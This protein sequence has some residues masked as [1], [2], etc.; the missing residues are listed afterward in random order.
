MFE[1]NAW[2]F[3]AKSLTYRL[4]VMS[5]WYHT[6]PSTIVDNTHQPKKGPGR[7]WTL[8]RMVFR[9]Q[10]EGINGRELLKTISWFCKQSRAARSLHGKRHRVRTM[11]LAS[12]DVFLILIASFKRSFS[13]KRPSIT[14]SPHGTT[15]ERET[16]QILIHMRQIDCMVSIDV[17]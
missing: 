8:R 13:T 16:F 11:R 12:V 10:C 14:P 6:Q 2:S 9:N 4:W 17:F 5:Q 7:W 1:H 15:T 3:M